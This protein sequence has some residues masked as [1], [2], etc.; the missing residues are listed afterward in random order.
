M[1]LILIAVFT[2]LGIILGKLLF[3][4]WF[5]H[6]TF[7]FFVMGGLIFLYELKFLP[8]PRLT[9]LTWFIIILATLSFLLGNLTIVSA[10][11]LFPQRKKYNNGANYSFSILIDNGTAVKYSILIFSIICLFAA[12]QHWVILLKI[13]GSIPA[14]FLN[15]GKIYREMS[16][17]E[18]KGIIPYIYYFGFVAVFFSGIYTA[19]NRRFTF[20]TFLPFLGIIIKELANLGR[21]GMLFAFL[22][23]LISFFLFRNLLNVSTKFRFFRL[24]AILASTILIVLLIVSAS[25][26]KV[27][28]SSTENYLGVS[29]EL[30][31][32]KDNLIISPSLYLYL[33]SD[34]GVLNQ[35]LGSE[36]EKT[37]FGQHTLL[38]VHDFFAKLGLEER[39]QDYQKGYYIPMWTNTGTYIREL[40][41]DFG[42]SGVLFG[43]YIIGLL[44]TWLWFK[45]YMENSSLIAFAVLVFLNIII[46]FS[47][48]VMVTRLLYWGAS[49]F[50]IIFYLPYLEKISL[51]I[52]R[53][54]KIGQD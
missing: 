43:P 36:G 52:S 50:F 26:V 45:F 12:V 41:A 28:R 24:N 11:N 42:L 32:T 46:G 25:F 13:Y 17:G 20:I 38:P 53:R 23:F 40:H 9:S 33:S 3:E 31:Q 49:L 29:K 5:N 18:I 1:S 39:P 2:F 48:L 51:A 8:Y 27:S 30:R 7:Y 10:R 4:R 15:A 37:K 16:K 44:I 22:E 19:Y 35:Y 6:L 14:V 34:I 21:T 54:K 47:F